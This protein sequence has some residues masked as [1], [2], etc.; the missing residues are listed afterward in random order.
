V[1]LTGGVGIFQKNDLTGLPLV[2]LGL[3]VF[4]ADGVLVTES[5]SETFKAFL[6]FTKLTLGAFIGSFVQRQVGSR[7]RKAELQRAAETVTRAGPFVPP[8]QAPARKGKAS[9]FRMNARTSGLDTR[10][11]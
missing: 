11:R 6:D 8:P 4:F 10:A 7:S 2:T 5:S 3:V 9:K 1:T